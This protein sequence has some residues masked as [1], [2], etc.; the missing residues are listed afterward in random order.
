MFATDSMVALKGGTG[1][2]NTTNNWAYV[3]VNFNPQIF[4]TKK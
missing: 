4:T 1:L 2:N 3:M